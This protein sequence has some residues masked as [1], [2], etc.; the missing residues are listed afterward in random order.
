MVVWRRHPTHREAILHFT[1]A[2]Q[3]WPLKA[4]FL[5][6]LCMP[7][8]AVA[9]GAPS[10]DGKLGGV[11]W[12]DSSVQKA[13]LPYGTI[14]ALYSNATLYI[15]VDMVLDEH[16]DGLFNGRYPPKGDGL[17]VI[18]DS[19]SAGKG[20]IDIQ[21]IAFTRKGDIGAPHRYTCQTCRTKDQKTLETKSQIAMGFGASP[22][23]ANP[24]L[25]WELSIPISEINAREGEAVRL[26][27]KFWSESPHIDGEYFPE[28]SD[29]ES[30]P[31]KLEFKL[32]SAQVQATAPAIAS[33]TLAA[34]QG[35]TMVVLDD[36]TIEVKSSDGM[37]SV[38]TKDGRFRLR[39]GD[40][41]PSST[42]VEAPAAILPVFANDSPMATWLE[43]H[44]T[45]L[46]KTI[47]RLLNDDP[48][49]ISNYLKSE[50]N[51]SVFNKIDRR[52]DVINFLST[53]P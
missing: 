12:T 47:K 14:K 44:N 46:L 38:L 5:F 42:P 34:S 39:P 33:T 15:A 25:I 37:R 45:G 23:S 19:S 41:L 31:R 53:T 43:S 3:K 2:P 52:A 10:I 16:D 8:I 7:A 30:S 21:D 35:R 27:L 20:N 50:R 40:Q 48:A 51:M 9:A 32:E 11:E 29:G 13:Q 18:F 1:P 49:L 4:A 36:G 17:D 6:I 24:H 26:W 22:D 28:L